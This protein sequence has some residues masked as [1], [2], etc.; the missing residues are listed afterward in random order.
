MG[1]MRT[2]GGA[3]AAL[4]TLGTLANL[5]TFVTL[6][7][8]LGACDA[9]VGNEYNGQ[10]LAVLTGT[11]ENQSLVP[12]AL[13]IDAALLWHA[14]GSN[15]LDAIMSATPVT[16][17]KTFPAQFT[18]T[19]Y[20]P[21]PA[22]AFQ[23]TTLP[24]AVADVGAIVHGATAADIASGAAVLGRL[25]DPVLFYFQST[26]PQGLMEQQY[27]S[28]KKGYHLISRQQ[29]VD[30]ATLSPSQID[31]CANTLSSQTRVAFADA[32]TECAQ[33]LLTEQSH[34]VPTSTP[35]LLRVRNP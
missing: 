25:T 15:P 6:A 9:Q 21:P 3:T 14:L 30:P 32:R 5:A 1:S 33:S 27:G 17:A 26:V 13:Q 20:L 7:T 16:I 23:Q 10:P 12:P 11:V 4:P 29:I 18:I 34:E 8:L 24:Y 31:A 22:M 2:T 19:V 35:L 28:L